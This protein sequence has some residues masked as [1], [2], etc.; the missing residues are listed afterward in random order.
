MVL[1]VGISFAHP[2]S[3]PTKAKESMQRY[4]IKGREG[5]AGARPTIWVPSN[6]LRLRTGWGAGPSWGEAVGRSKD[7]GLRHDGW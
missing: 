5:L 6:Q 1:G 3:Q 7:S 4:N 2:T